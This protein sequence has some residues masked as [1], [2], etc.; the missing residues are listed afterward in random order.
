MSNKCVYA[1]STNRNQGSLH[2]A[3]KLQYGV[4]P[5]ILVHSQHK[6]EFLLEEW[7]K[8]KRAVPLSEQRSCGQF[9][10]KDAYTTPPVFG[11]N[12]K[13]IE[14]RRLRHILYSNAFDNC[15]E[16]LTVSFRPP[17]LSPKSSRSGP[18]GSSAT[19]C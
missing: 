1:G 3:W 7:I 11:S 6:L 18:I 8:L 13:V 16:I 15:G 10:C 9:Q 12:Q 2:P 17:R 19:H 4:F 5:V 14:L